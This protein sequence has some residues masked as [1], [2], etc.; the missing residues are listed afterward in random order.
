MTGYVYFELEHTAPLYAC[1]HM[2]MI[3]VGAWI[4]SWRCR[5]EH[6][7]SR[8]PRPER[9]PINSRSVRNDAWVCRY[10]NINAKAF[11]DLY[12]VLQVAVYADFS[13]RIIRSTKSTYN[14]HL[15]KMRATVCATAMIDPRD[16]CKRKR[17]QRLR[18][19]VNLA[20]LS[21]CTRDCRLAILLRT[22]HHESDNSCLGLSYRAHLTA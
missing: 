19:S 17:H 16:L 21:Q 12:A 4:I 9:C 5:P 20:N 14:E 3:D 7:K 10:V 11:S 13:H 1:G 22:P 18:L 8:G 6:R 15:W 2:G